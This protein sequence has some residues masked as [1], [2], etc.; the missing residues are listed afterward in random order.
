[1]SDV[2]P[3]D[4]QGS[5]LKDLGVDDSIGEAAQSGRGRGKKPSVLSTSGSFVLMGGGGAAG[6]AGEELGE[7][8][9]DQEWKQSDDLDRNQL[10]LSVQQL[11]DQLQSNDALGIDTKEQDL[12]EPNQ[13]T[14]AWR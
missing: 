4:S 3:L 9:E 7:D 8:L 6:G 13:A 11:L 5:A 14:R 1:L 12:G 10:I 2:T